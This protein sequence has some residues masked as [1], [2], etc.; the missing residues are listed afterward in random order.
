MEPHLISTADYNIFITAEHPIVFKLVETIIAQTDKTKNE[1]LDELDLLT[2]IGKVEMLVQTVESASYRGKMSLD[3]NGHYAYT[4]DQGIYDWH[5]F[6]FLKVHAIVN[7]DNKITSMKWQNKAT[8]EYVKS[9]MSDRAENIFERLK[10]SNFI[11]DYKVYSL[12]IP[13]FVNY[14]ISKGD[15]PPRDS[16][17][18]R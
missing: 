3:E 4:D 7:H 16:G 17:E 12:P 10:I 14:T 1:V 9:L 13:P 6:H 8:A 11:E 15:P 18:F 2:K 5:R